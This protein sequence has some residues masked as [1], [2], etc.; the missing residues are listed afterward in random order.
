VILHRQRAFDVSVEGAVPPAFDDID[1]FA[2]AGRKG[3]FMRSTTVT[4]TDGF[5]DIDFVRF[6]S[7]PN[8]KAIEIILDCSAP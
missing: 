6:I 7:D 2:I 5:L 4:V 3:A 8:I 1:Q